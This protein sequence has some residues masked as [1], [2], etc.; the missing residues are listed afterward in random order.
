M[1][2]IGK[3]RRVALMRSLIHG[4]RDLL[5]VAAEHRVS[6]EQLAD[7]AA[8]DAVQRRLAHLCGLADAQAQFQVSRFR[9]FVAQQLMRDA[10]REG[11]DELTRKTRLDAMKAEVWQPFA[12]A[13]VTPAET[14]DDDETAAALRSLLAC[15]P[16]EGGR[17]AQHD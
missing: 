13:A 14:N 10:M 17:D 2:A 6:L 9:L 12:P 11:G 3:D 5:D 16:E 4:E 15:D 7:W 1:P 8:D